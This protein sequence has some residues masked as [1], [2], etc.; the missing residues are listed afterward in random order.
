MAETPASNS[1]L[2]RANFEPPASSSPGGVSD[3]RHAPPTP[4]S[5]EPTLSG[6]P[7]HAAWPGARLPATQRNSFAVPLRQKPLQ[8]RATGGPQPRA[9]L[10]RGL[11]PAAAPCFWRA[12][13]GRSVSQPHQQA[14]FCGREPR[15]LRS[16]Q[17]WSGRSP[18]QK[19]AS[20]TGLVLPLFYEQGQVL[21][22]PVRGNIN[23]EKRASPSEIH[24]REPS[25]SSGQKK[26]P[27]G[28]AAGG[29]RRPARKCGDTAPR[30]RKQPPAMQLRHMKTVQQSYI[31]RCSY[32]PIVP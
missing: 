31:A 12:R 8:P 18:E 24:H 13:F 5:S 3:R 14:V 6:A 1:C 20:F 28:S 32:V 10:S 26:P 22:S 11:R 29:S 7:I 2:Q 27:P 25:L 17:V 15:R 19:V 9:Y 23:R 21:H 4:A 16:A 30:T